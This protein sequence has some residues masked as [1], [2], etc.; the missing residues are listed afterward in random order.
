MA[1]YNFCWQPR[2]LGRSH[3]ASDSGR[4]GESAVDVRGIDGAVKLEDAMKRLLL[5]I[6]VISAVGCSVVTEEKPRARNGRQIPASGTPIY[7]DMAPFPVP[8]P[9]VPFDGGPKIS[10]QR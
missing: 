1:Y 5:A 7:R 10:S 2:T 9:E 6:I 3:D 4:V 8:A